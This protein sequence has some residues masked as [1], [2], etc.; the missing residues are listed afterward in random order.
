MGKVI[1]MKKWLKR[2]TRNSK[3]A[4][5]LTSP[6]AVNLK[7]VSDEIDKIVVQSIESGLITSSQMAGLLSHRL[8]SLLR[9]LGNKSSLYSACTEVLRKQA[10]ISD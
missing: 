5:D 3:G 6:E 2:Q 10:S 9:L 1:S 4:L 8:G 7:K